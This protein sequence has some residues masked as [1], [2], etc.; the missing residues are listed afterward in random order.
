M[1]VPF[2]RLPD[3]ARIWIYASNR[4]FTQEEAEAVSARLLNHCESWNAHGTQL[5]TSFALLFHR[6][7]VFG[8]NQDAHS[9]SGCSIDSSVQVLRKIEADYRVQLL[10][11][12][13]VTFR[14]EEGSLLEE[15]PLTEF[16]KLIKT[17]E[18]SGDELIYQH[19]LL[20]KAQL[21]G[22]FEMPLKQ[23]WAAPLLPQPVND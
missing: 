2:N 12:A 14:R 7:I 18:L 9:P 21:E 1:Y 5:E 8:V 22:E 17:G 11:A 19:N 10:D 13:R 3:N 16:R 4:T 15:L 20:S 23:S 6:F